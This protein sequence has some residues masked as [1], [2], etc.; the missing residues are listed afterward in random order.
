MTGIRQAAIEGDSQVT[1]VTS[2]SPVTPYTFPDN[3][4]N[5]AS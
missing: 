2:L 5:P 1:P 4:Q 3:H